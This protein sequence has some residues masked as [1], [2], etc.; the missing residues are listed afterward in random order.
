MARLFAALLG[1]C[2][3]LAA[4]CGGAA[5]QSAVNWP[6][7]PI[8]AIMPIAPGTGA[9]VIFRLVFNELSNRLGQ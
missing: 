4:A 1:A 2:G 6:T 8:R 3:L 7:K 5:A 9:D